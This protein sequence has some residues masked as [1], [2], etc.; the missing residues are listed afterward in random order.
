MFNDKAFQ[1]RYYGELL[2]ENNPE[3]FL[4][5]IFF[6]D[7]LKKINL[8]CLDGRVN[9]ILHSDFLNIKDFFLIFLSFLKVNFLK[10]KKI[11]FD[12]FDISKLILDEI[13]EKRY[14]HALLNSV[15]NFYLLRN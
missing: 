3:I 15:I 6:N 7:S 5:P 1:D 13:S 10:E 12:G 8:S 9:Y 2:R 11:L 14:S 4:L